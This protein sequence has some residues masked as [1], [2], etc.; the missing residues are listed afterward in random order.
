MARE[1]IHTEKF[2]RC[3]VKVKAQKRRTGKPKDPYAVCMSSIGREEA[4]RKEHWDPDYKPPKDNRVH[5]SGYARSDGTKVKGYS[6][7]RKW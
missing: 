2:D 7:R 6:Y 4:V 3:V 5:V 1:D